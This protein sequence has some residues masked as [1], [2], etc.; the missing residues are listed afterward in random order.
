MHRCS[1]LPSPNIILYHLKNHVHSLMPVQYMKILF[2][3]PILCCAVIE[4]GVM[5]LYRTLGNI[6]LTVQAASSC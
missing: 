4:I 3:S 2:V 6:V 5:I 1:L